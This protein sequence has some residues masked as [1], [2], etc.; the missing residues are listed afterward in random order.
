MLKDPHFNLTGN[1]TEQLIDDH[2]I[3]SCGISTQDIKKKGGWDGDT[4]A[5]A[6]GL[7]I[8]PTG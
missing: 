6:V 4:A 5:L 1:I 8:S 2:I 3:L 7:T